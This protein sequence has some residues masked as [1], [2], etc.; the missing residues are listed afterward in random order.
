[1][2]YSY[3][4]IRQYLLGPRLYCH[5]CLEDSKE[6]DPQAAMLFGRAF[7]LALGAYFRREDPGEVLFL[8]WSA[9]KDQGLEFFPRDTWDRMLE[10]GIKLLIRFRQDD[11]VHVFEPLSCLQI[12]FARA[13]G[14]SEFVA[15]IDA[16]GTLD[17][18]P[19]LLEW[20]TSSA[21]YAE[22]PAGTLAL[23]PQLVCYSWIT[24]IP[25]V[26]KVVF[27][28]EPMVEIQYLR[29]TI[30]EL[31]RQQF[32]RLVEDT[33]RRMDSTE[34]LQYGPIRRTAGN[35]GRELGTAHRS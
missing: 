35:R 33:I 20:K 9:C 32:G 26:A 10:Q 4:Q 25:E 12:K 13:V 18:K 34:R 29:T 8:E 22:G 16:I 3:T 19:Y 2:I 1:M 17:W 6:T 23:D 14:K 11:R 5:R 31:Q 30:T 15:Y 24:G 21:R 7:E 27:V 28:R